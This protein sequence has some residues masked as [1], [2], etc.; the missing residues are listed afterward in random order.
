M[1]QDF[2]DHSSV[3]RSAESGYDRLRSHGVPKDAARRISEQAAVITHKAVD[4]PPK[5][6]D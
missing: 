6:K 1:S 2:R 3:R 5:K 4:A